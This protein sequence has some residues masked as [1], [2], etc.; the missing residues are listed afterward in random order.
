MSVGRFVP[1]IE[2][3]KRA[4]VSD[5]LEENLEEA[6]K[7]GPVSNGNTGTRSRNG[8]QNIKKW[9]LVNIDLG[10]CQNG[11]GMPPFHNPKK[12][13]IKHPLCVVGWG[14]LV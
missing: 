4:E 7:A 10:L 5:G 9:I 6:L 14:V 3:S 12:G 11:C 2:R 13:S 8:T 1:P